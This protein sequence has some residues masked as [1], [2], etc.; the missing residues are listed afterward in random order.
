[1]SASSRLSIASPHLRV[2]WP[3][4]PPRVRP[5]TPVVEMIPLGVASPYAFVAWSTSPQVQ[6]PPTRAVRASGS[7]SMSRISERSI[8]SPSSQVPSPAPLW[9]PPRTA[10]GRS[11]SRAK[12]MAAA[13]SSAVA[14][15][16]INAGRLVDHCVVD[17]ARF[18]VLGILWPDQRAIELGQLFTCRACGCGPSAH[19]VLLI[20]VCCCREARGCGPLVR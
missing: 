18:A 2:R 20:R 15:R 19:S 10:S 9:P 14:H 6:P 1:M 8:T 12:P 7:T 17:L 5:P 3:R 16:A 11:W 13:T 4:P